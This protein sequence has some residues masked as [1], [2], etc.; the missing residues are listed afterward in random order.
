MLISNKKMSA[1]QKEL[2]D[3]LHVF[4]NF[5]ISAVFLLVC[6][7]Q[8][9]TNPNCN[10]ITVINILLCVVVQQQ[11]LQA[12]HLSHGHA[13]P[14]PIT[15]HPAGLQPP[16]PPGASTASLLALS[17]ALSHQLPLKDERKHHDNNSDHPRGEGRSACVHTFVLWFVSMCVRSWSS[18]LLRFNTRTVAHKRHEIN[19]PEFME[20]LWWCSEAGSR[21]VVFIRIAYSKY[22][23]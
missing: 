23:Q 11:Q 2:K 7:K 22:V 19:K 6:Y 15:P 17:S 14:I 5:W 1:R 10:S 3:K 21:G 8:E 12:Q 18:Q 20:M 9:W 4:I 16:L 13:I